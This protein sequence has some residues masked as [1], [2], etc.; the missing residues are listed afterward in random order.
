MPILFLSDSG[1]HGELLFSLVSE[2][3]P[4]TWEKAEFGK[5]Q[6]CLKNYEAIV[7]DGFP[8]TAKNTPSV[9]FNHLKSMDHPKVFLINFPPD[10]PQHIR[11][12]LNE[13]KFLFLSDNRS[14]QKDLI[15]KLG[16]AIQN[17]SANR[18]NAGMGRPLLTKREQEIL[19]ELTNGEPNSIIASRL[20]LSE[21]TVKNHMY[22]I[23][24]KIGV[25]NRLQ[26]SNWAKLH[27][28]TEKI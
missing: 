12:P 10:L 16:L 22:N 7:V 15:S 8:L 26:A 9:E 13:K 1:L 18:A 17:A 24:R 21:H 20:H 2:S 6:H 5:Q 14:N 27:L 11:Q 25:K 3:L 28:Q 19:A 4:F 23:F